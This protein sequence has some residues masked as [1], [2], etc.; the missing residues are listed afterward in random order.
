MSLADVSAAIAK[1]KSD[2]ASLQA[3]LGATPP[4]P[5]GRYVAAG[6]PSPSQAEIAAGLTNVVF[7]DHFDD[8]MTV[9]TAFSYDTSKVN[10][11]FDGWRP[12]SD[13]LGP[14]TNR[15]SVA[16]SMLHL[17]GDYFIDAFGDVV[18]TLPQ[19][20]NVPANT[21]VAGISFKGSRSCT[22]AIKCD[23]AGA[24]NFPRSWPTMW[25]MSKQQQLNQ[26]P[27]IETDHFEWMPR[28]MTAPFVAAPLF[29]IRQC[30]NTNGTWSAPVA[31][32]I[33]STQLPT[34]FD[35]SEMNLVQTVFKDPADFGGY[36]SMQWFVARPGQPFVHLVD[37]D[38]N[39]TVGDG[40]PWNTLS[41]ESHY[42]I[43]G[44]GANF[45]AWFDYV[46][47]RQ[48]PNVS[49]IQN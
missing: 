46:C 27:H 4:P 10:W 49:L 15:V 45:P 2:A 48:L 12:Q 34:V 20:P 5:V 35:L 30:V 36:G 47:V 28:G 1:V 43:L 38:L 37:C 9:D 22:C 14:I 13:A 18:N 40:S 24:A 32:S 44:A 16:N 8:P 23:P 41:Q 19:L 39:W 25:G 21:Q 33:L 42:L 6:A 31:Q 11:M 29:S 3:F 17:S 7:F 26:S